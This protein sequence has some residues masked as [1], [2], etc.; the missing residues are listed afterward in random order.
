MKKFKFISF[1]LIFFI[2]TANLVSPS[3]Y[4]LSDPGPQSKAVV[5]LDAATGNVLYTKAENE[6]LYPASTTKIMTVLLAVEAIEAG[7]VNLTDSVTASGN[8]TAG[9]S[10]DGSTAGIVPGETMTL[11]N[12]LYCAMLSSAN[13]ACNIIAEYIGGDIGSFVKMMNARAQE[14]GCTGTNF[15]NTHGYPDYNHYTTSSD[16]AKIAYEA[17]SHPLFMQICNTAKKT[18]PA[19][20]SS[21]ERS[22]N[23]TN[24]LINSDSETYPG[25]FYEYA[26]GMKTGHTQDAGYC[27][28][29]TASKNGVTLLCV[30]LGGQA[31]GKVDN[32]EYTNFSDSIKLYDWA[33]ENYSYRDI[34][35]TT[36]LVKDIPV[37]MGREADYVTVHPQNAVRALMPNDEDISSFEQKVTIYSEQNGDE[38]VAP[39]E[40]GTVLGEIT[41]ERDGT[42][43]GKSQL[44]ACASVDLSYSQHIK[45]QIAKT[46]KKPVVII[47]LL[48]VLAFVGFYIYLVVHYR[49]EKKRRTREMEMRRRA[50]ERAA[51]N[52]KAAINNPPTRSSAVPMRYFEEDEKEMPARPARTKNNEVLDD[53]LKA[54]RDYF[55]EFFGKNKQ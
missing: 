38:L 39:I 30:V 16:L 31:V 54:E 9:L 11:E 47:F 26:A 27:L 1:I 13:E 41:V 20:N 6:K 35:E 46:L 33:F 36:D 40:A 29:S 55:E 24:G 49:T 3:A 23:N 43:Y 53:D 44:V 50:Q 32:T 37:K 22:L 34:L 48:L 15:A 8:I 10:D 14:L 2:L 12:L 51:A 17:Y 45:S 28:V 4:A 19:T 42:V 7:K 5:L 21:P 18:I 25:Y 52:K